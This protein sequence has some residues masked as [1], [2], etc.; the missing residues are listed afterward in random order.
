MPDS[1]VCGRDVDSLETVTMEPWEDRLRILETEVAELR[2]REEIRRVLSRYARAVDEK[3]PEVLT[4]IFAPE[5]TLR[6]IPW[7]VEANGRE[8][9]LEFFHSYW[10]RFRDPHRYY[11]NDDIKINGDRAEASAYFFL[12]QASEDDSVLSWG[13][14]QWRF[15]LRAGSWL[16]TAQT[17]RIKVMTTLDSGW[18]VPNQVMA[19]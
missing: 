3:R 2:A 1:P 19:L 16:A 14:Y 18:S 8:A 4:E 15:V 6:V 10:R 11:T 9:V 7:D 13:T 12:L 17:V 5:M